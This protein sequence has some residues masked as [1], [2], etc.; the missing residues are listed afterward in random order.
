MSLRSGILLAVAL[1]SSACTSPCLQLAE[2][3][4]NCQNNENARNTCNSEE[5]TRNSQVNPTSDQENA[6]SALL[7][8]CDCNTIDTPQGKID[9][10]LAR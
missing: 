5:G 1:A 8:K 10:G 3:I 6:C 4:C 2:N 9:C 7:D